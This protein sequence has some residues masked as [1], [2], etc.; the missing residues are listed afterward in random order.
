[1][2]VKRRHPLR[3]K[4]QRELIRQLAPTPLLHR[5][6]REEGVKVRVEHLLLEGDVELFLVGGRPWLVRRGRVTFP[7]LPAL[8]EM[9][10]ELPRVVVDMGAVRHIARGADVMVPGIVEVEGNVKQGDLVV[11]VDQTHRS[12]LAVGASLMEDEE[13]RAAGKGRAIHTLHHVGDNLWQFMKQL[14]G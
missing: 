6:L 11:V 3:S 7:A 10:V 5:S 9:A 1:M 2:R 14:V 8:R 12:P 4:E 13:M